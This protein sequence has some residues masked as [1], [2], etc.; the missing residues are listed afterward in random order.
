[1]KNT[2]T[3]VPVIALLLLAIQSHAQCVSAYS[4]GSTNNVCSGDTVHLSYSYDSLCFKPVCSPVLDSLSTTYQLQSGTAFNAKSI[5][6]NFYKGY[7]YQFLYTAADLQAVFDTGYIEQVAWR[8]GT[9]NSNAVLQNFTISIKT[10]SPDS[11]KLTNWETGMTMVYSVQTYTPTVTLLTPWNSHNL[12]TPFYWDGV[13]GLVIEVRYYN[14]NTSNNMMNLMSVTADTGKV[15]Y[16]MANA[17]VYANQTAPTV[18]N[19]R[20]VLRLKVCETS[21]VPVQDTL[22]WETDGPDTVEYDLGGNAFAKITAPQNF[23]VSMAKKG[24]LKNSAPLEVTTITRPSVTTGATTICKG[25]SA[26]V[27]T[28]IPFDSYSW[29]TGDTSATITTADS[30]WYWVTTTKG[31]CVLQSVDSVYITVAPPINAF[32]TI[33]SGS[34]AGENNLIIS[35]PN[36]SAYWL[37]RAVDTLTNAPTGYT[38]TGTQVT[39]TC[40]GDSASSSDGNYVRVIVADVNGCTDTTNW[41]RLT[42]CLTGLRDYTAQLDFSVFPNPAEEYC[43]VKTAGLKGD[44]QIEI[45]DMQGRVVMQHTYTPRQSVTALPVNTSQLATGTYMVRIFAEGKSGQTL[46]VK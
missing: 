44:V 20:P 41:D 2:F 4:T 26:T 16:A 39:L 36:A 35:P 3:L 11:S 40:Y 12:T 5:Y 34:N 22:Y 23:K 9:Y 14:P 24:V 7:R 8:I 33:T 25:Q 38:L 21:E 29:N 42:N 17:D 6:G 31:S 30:G 37:E 27:Y 15:L 1:M 32:F 18:W 10:I 19:E 45:T 13:S 46:L 43:Y 28:Q